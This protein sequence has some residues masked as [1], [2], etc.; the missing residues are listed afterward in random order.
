MLASA[1]FEIKFDS[2]YRSRREVLGVTDGIRS[3]KQ[4]PIRSTLGD[5]FD[6]TEID[7]WQSKLVVF[8]GVLMVVFGLIGIFLERKLSRY[9]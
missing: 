7:P 3:D 2:I 9:Q 1:G 4:C 6:E 5:G 8:V